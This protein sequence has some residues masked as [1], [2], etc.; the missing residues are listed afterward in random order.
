MMLSSD[1]LHRLSFAQTQFRPVYQIIWIDLPLFLMT[2]V[3]VLMYCLIY[4][5]FFARQRETWP[6]VPVLCVV[7]RGFF[8]RK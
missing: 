2:G 4:P 3:T 1:Y 8:R 7:S 5:V 6:A